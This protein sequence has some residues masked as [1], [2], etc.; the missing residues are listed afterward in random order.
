M[1]MIAAVVPIL[2]LP[3]V[4]STGDPALDAIAA[5]YGDLS[6][7]LGMQPVDGHGSCPAGDNCKGFYTYS[8]LSEA[9]ANWNTRSGADEKFLNDQD[10]ETNARTLAA[11]VA[12]VKYETALF[13]ACK[14]RLK[15]ADG[16][17]PAGP[18]KCSGGK[19]GDYTSAKAKASGSWTVTKCNGQ[20]AATQGCTDFWGNTLDGENCWYGRGALQLS[21]PGNY[22][23]VA[24]A[25]KTGSNVDI[26]DDPD[27]I[28]NSA[29]TA[30]SASMAYWK[31]NESPWIHG[32]SNPDCMAYTFAC[33]LQV[34]RPADTST[35]KEREEQYVKYLKAMGITGPAPPPKPVK[36]K[37][38]TCTNIKCSD[39]S[40]GCNGSTGCCPYTD[41]PT[42]TG[43]CSCGTSWPDA[44]DSGIFCNA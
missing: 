3:V 25:I 8:H 39:G 21:W 13:T 30:F 1:M 12:N 41:T 18:N 10:V 22:N 36:P 26:C 2:S 11:F 24:A 4:D 44:R 33:A 23:N 20:T 43:F 29:T 7:I 19:V 14:E 6:S 40:T 27:A 32:N 28:C 15:L 5:K 38:G 16:T 42:G 17:C 37:K 31:L 9:I 34:V 35:N